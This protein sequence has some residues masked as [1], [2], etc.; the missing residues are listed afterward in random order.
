MES[1]IY[2]RPHHRGWL[3]MMVL[4][5]NSNDHNYCLTI[6]LY[7]VSLVEKRLWLRLNRATSESARGADADRSGG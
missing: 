1:S 3:V 4:F 7:E 6:D 5:F 2:T